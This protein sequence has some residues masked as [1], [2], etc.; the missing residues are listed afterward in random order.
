MCLI[1]TTSCRA[2]PANRF[3]RKLLILIISKL[4]ISLLC[5]KYFLVIKEMEIFM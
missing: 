1:S 3:Q 2:A 4:V 5:F